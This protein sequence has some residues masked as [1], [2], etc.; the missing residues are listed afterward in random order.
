MASKGAYQVLK[1]RFRDDERFRK[2]FES[3]SWVFVGGLTLAVGLTFLSTVEYVERTDP[4]RLHL[5]RTRAALASLATS[6]PIDDGTHVPMPEEVRGIYMTSHSAGSKR[7]RD[8]LVAYMERNDINSVVIDVKDGSGRL[9]FTP[10]APEL[11]DYAPERVTMPDMDDFL[12]ELGEKDIYRI[13]RVFVFQDPYYVSIRPDEAVKTKWGTVWADYKGVTWVDAASRNAWDY[14]VAIAEEIYRRGFDEIQFDYIRFPSDGNLD[15]IEYTHHDPAVQSKPEVLG[16]FYEYMYRELEQ[17]RGIPISYDLFGYV[18]WHWGK[19]DLGIGQ[20]LEYALPYATAI[21]AMVYPSHYGYGT[22]GLGNPADYPYEIIADSLR[23]ANGLNAEWE[24]QCA[25]G[26]EDPIMPC[27]AELG[28]HRPWIQAFDIGAVYD[29]RKYWDQIRASRDQ[30]AKGWL[31]W[32]ARNVYRDFNVNGSGPPPPLV[33]GAATST[34]PLPV[35]ASVSS[36][37]P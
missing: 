7:I 30:G 29:A 12:A 16:E 8:R 24:R 18:T 13:A 3:A 14:N 2:L 35:E 17:R 20:Q 22:L 33:E 5:L 26:V 25:E 21:S 6:L 32:N 10:N 28:H 1:E 15:S 34:P 19:Y 23:K 37:L 4:S 9:S 27:D 11:Q 31:L 36:T